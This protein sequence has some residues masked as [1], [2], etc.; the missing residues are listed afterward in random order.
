MKTSIKEILLISSIILFFAGIWMREYSLGLILFLI[1]VF[2]AIIN[3][4]IN[5]LEVIKLNKVKMEEQKNNGS[6]NRKY[7]T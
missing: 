5:L 6:T 7:R 1:G 2:F 4:L 3:I